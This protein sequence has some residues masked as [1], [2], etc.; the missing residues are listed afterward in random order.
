MD[1]IIIN[2]GNRLKGVIN[3]SGAK[4]AVLPILGASLLCPGINVIYD[5]PSLK[6]VEVMSS[7]LEYLGASVSRNGKIITVDTSNVEA[8]D[9]S[10]ELMRRMRASNLVLGPLLG[11]FGKVRISQPG[12]CNIGSRPMDLHLKGIRA[13]GASIKEQWGYITAEAGRLV[14]SEIHLD[15][16][17]VG[18]TEN[19][20]MAAV[21]AKGE[22]IIY[23][24]AREP[25]IVDLQ[26][27]LNKAGACIKGAGTSVIRIKGVGSLHPCKHRVIPDR[28][29]AG[30]HMVAAAI[31]NGDITIQNVITE[32]IEPMVAKLREAGIDVEMEN[33]TVHVR[34]TGKRYAIDIRTMP[35]PGFPT[36]MQPQMTALL[37]VTPGTS[38][39]T[40]N[41]FENRFKHVPEL[42]RMGADIKVESRT[43]VVCGVKKL[44]GATVRA[45]DLR[46][47][48][49]LVLAG[50]A[51]E[52]TTV[53]EC[54]EHIDRGYEN[55][56]EK[57]RQLG[58]DI[59][60][61]R[62]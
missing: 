24:A 46:A 41:I 55:L 5:V 3:V 53:I 43:A 47:G 16:P 15:V 2:G 13:L 28:I 33:N 8:R 27:F 37:S 42:H 52:G 26:T 17:S 39:I 12:G 9:V 36:D 23:N 20:I 6:D 49:A 50:L 38:L 21:L 10:E 32:H 4:N 60:R 1:R 40:E 62:V 14:G 31:T 35:Y 11:R 57:Y 30:T 48:A 56:E 7:L 29:E 45:T 25:E 18:A 59:Y 19:I 61:E 51:A 34:A 54:P 44:S 22:T 58:A